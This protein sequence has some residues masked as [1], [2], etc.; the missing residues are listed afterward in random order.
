MIHTDTFN[1]GEAA[2]SWQVQTHKAKCDLPV[3]RGRRGRFRVW[4]G[5]TGLDMGMSAKSLQQIIFLFAVS[6]FWEV[7]AV[8]LMQPRFL[9]SRFLHRCPNPACVQV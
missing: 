2:P 8:W 4:Q 6:L 3:N 7:L 9:I 5:E 1:Q